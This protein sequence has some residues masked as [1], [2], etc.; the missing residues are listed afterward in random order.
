MTTHLT[1]EREHTQ[2]G[3]KLYAT[4]V[5]DGLYLGVDVLLVQE[6]LQYQP[7]TSIPLSSP[8]IEGL[9]NLRGQIVI[10]I[11]M[12]RRLHLPPRPRDWMPKNVVLQT[13]EGAVSLLVDEIGDVVEVSKDMFE[14]PPQNVD[15]SARELLEGVYKLKDRLL[16]ILDIDKTINIA[17]EILPAPNA[18]GKPEL[19]ETRERVLSS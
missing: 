17:S 6:V 19:R 3:N 9:I 14:K 2:A 15:R 18:S 13:G 11:D 10:A 1:R 7:M 12:R 16:L 4:F 8:V 5:V